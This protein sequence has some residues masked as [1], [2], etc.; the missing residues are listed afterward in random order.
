VKQH[1][2]NHK[3]HDALLFIDEDW[4]LPLRS[5]AMPAGF[6]KQLKG[7]YAQ[8]LMPCCVSRSGVSRYHHELDKDGKCIYCDKVNPWDGAHTYRGEMNENS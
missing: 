5:H 8:P 1:K 4:R 6:I 3:I 7:N 2:L